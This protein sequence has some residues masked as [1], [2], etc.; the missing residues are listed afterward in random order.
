MSNV[1]EP[2]LFHY[3]HEEGPPR[4]ID[5]AFLNRDLIDS[6]GKIREPVKSILDLVVLG[7]RRLGLDSRLNFTT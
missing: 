3:L 5:I 1:C 7:Y 2:F 4:Y 6:D